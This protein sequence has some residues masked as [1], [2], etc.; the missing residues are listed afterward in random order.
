MVTNPYE[1]IWL[2]RQRMP[3]RTYLRPGREEL[4]T[5]CM[6]GGG[7]IQDMQHETISIFFSDLFTAVV[8]MVCSLFKK[9][10]FKGLFI[11]ESAL[12]LSTPLKYL[13]TNNSNTSEHNRI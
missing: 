1:K 5:L 7:G 13:E 2:G 11:V 3:I 6:G 4:S 9:K 12:S 8:N 10:R